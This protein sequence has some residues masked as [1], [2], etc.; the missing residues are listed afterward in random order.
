MGTFPKQI[1]YIVGNEACERF[2]YYG[3]VSILTLYLS[4]VIRL[5]EDRATEIFHLFATAVYF[6]PILGGWL[7]DRF[8]GRYW[9][10]LSLSLFYCLGHGAL[11]L[12]EGKLWG[13]YL[14][15]GLIALG[16]GAIKPNVSAF[17][18]EQFRENDEDKLRK[19]YALFYWSINIGAFFGFLLIPWC[20]DHAGYSWAFGI[21]GFFMALAT[22]IF[23]SG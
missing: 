13:I 20:R 17:V 16:A 23:W 19:V 2:S 14:G 15:L 21:P 7:A 12:F 18:G 5:G 22:I 4:D 3:M 9:T 10:I 8:L 11:A 1:K 6:L